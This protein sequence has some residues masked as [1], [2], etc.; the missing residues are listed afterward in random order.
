MKISVKSV[1][2]FLSVLLFLFL[3]WYFRS[4]V[5]YIFISGVLSIIGG[6]L[7]NIFCKLHVGKWRFPRALSAL[8]TLF[9]IWGFVASFL[10]IFVPLVT[11]QVNFFA[12]IDS[13]SIMALFEEPL[14]KIETF[15]R[16]INAEF[17]GDVSIK[18][19]FMQKITSLFNID[20]LQGA[21]GSAVGVVGDIVISVFA[22]SFITFFFL[23]DQHLFFDSILMWIP[24]KYTEGFSRALSS[25]INLLT[26]YF[27][28][29]LCESMLVMILID[30]GMTVVG[31]DFQQALVMGLIIGVLNVIPYIGPW[32][33]FFVAMLMGIASHINM[34]FST[35]VGPLMIYMAIVVAITQVIDNIFFQPIIYSNS[36][37]AHPLE[38]FIVVLAFGSFAGVGGM[39]L[40]IP[41]YTVIRVLAKEFFS[42]F[43]A[44]QK[45]TSGLDEPD[46]S[47]GIFKKKGEKKPPIMNEEK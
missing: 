25:I 19:F 26:R 14:I 47:R 13:S 10:L 7:V 4:I 36:V 5:V 23:K 9:I 33:G 46:G 38:I 8:L 6:P 45:I 28:G 27:I 35:V 16:S 39:I 18:T 21:L 31:I 42:N 43:K 17:T 40:G 24:E 22:V 20:L 2:A 41:S 15:S 37:K 29:I 3:V 34:D 30:I 32:I 11:K 12:S 1:V 44:I